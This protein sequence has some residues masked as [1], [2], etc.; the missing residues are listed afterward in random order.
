[1][2]NYITLVGVSYKKRPD[3]LAVLLYSLLYYKIINRLLNF[4]LINQ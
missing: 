2:E 1:M 4:S 3:N